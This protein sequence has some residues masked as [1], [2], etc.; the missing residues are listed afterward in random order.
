MAK[1]TKA[2]KAPVHGLDTTGRSF[3]PTGFR[4]SLA[5]EER[6]ATT[7]SPGVERVYVPATG[8]GGRE[9]AAD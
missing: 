7:E 3:H 2:G 6:A 1:Q 5:E 8:A 9:G 4:G